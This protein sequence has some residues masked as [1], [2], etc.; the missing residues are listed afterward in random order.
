M[1]K[2]GLRAKIRWARA[3]TKGGAVCHT[4]R[5][6]CPRVRECPASSTRDYRPFFD[7]HVIGAGCLR[8]ESLCQTGWC[9]HPYHS[10]H[11]PKNVRRHFGWCGLTGHLRVGAIDIDSNMGI[12]YNAIPGKRKTMISWK[13][14]YTAF[15]GRPA[16]Q[17]LVRKLKSNRD[18]VR[19]NIR[20][21]PL[22][23]FDT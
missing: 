22:D 14:R 12:I 4:Y 9:I 2:W 5:L 7:V 3:A 23:Q 13:D 16:L 1:G 17:Q 8:A 20:R 6:H 19:K 15:Q 11:W 18:L 10:R 21:Y